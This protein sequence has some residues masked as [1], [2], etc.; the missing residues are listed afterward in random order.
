MFFSFPV[1]FPL[2][3]NLHYNLYPRRERERERER[4]FALCTLMLCSH[5]WYP[6]W[7]M[8]DAEVNENLSENPR[9][10]IKRSLFQDLVCKQ[11]VHQKIAY[12]TYW[13]ILPFSCEF[14]QLHFPGPRQTERE[15]I[16]SD[17][18]FDTF[19]VALIWHLLNTDQESC[20]CTSWWV[21]CLAKRHL[22]QK[23]MFNLTWR[24]RNRVSSNFVI[25]MKT[26]VHLRDSV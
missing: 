10:A 8:A 7:S 13:Q 2:W 5:F 4:I 17:L 14:I 3:Y 23:L 24:L 26:S 1:F 15:I 20:E 12:F 6:K 25:M 16:E 9:T 22:G 19:C 11:G 18:W 21:L